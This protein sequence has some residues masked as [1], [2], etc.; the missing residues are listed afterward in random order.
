MIGKVIQINDFE[1][2]ARAGEP[3]TFE[4]VFT[5]QPCA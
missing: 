3:F 2:P 1:L 5:N 4:G